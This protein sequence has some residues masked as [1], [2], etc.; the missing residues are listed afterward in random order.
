MTF[1]NLKIIFKSPYFN[2]LRSCSGDCG[3]DEEFQAAQFVLWP[4]HEDN[5]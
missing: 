5:I 2:R 3:S 4:E 1:E